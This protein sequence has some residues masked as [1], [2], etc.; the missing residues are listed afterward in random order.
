MYAVFDYVFFRVYDFYKRKNS[1]IPIDRG[2]QMLS[3]IQGTLLMG[4]IMIVDF[5]ETVINR[6]VANKYIIGVPVAIAILIINEIRYKRM[7]KKNQF[8]LFYERWENEDKILR[9][10]KGIVIVMLPVFLLFGI[11]ILLWFIKQMQ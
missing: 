9:K 6:E 10:N 11:P 3:I 5:F 1:D 8:A 7:A 4:I 2:I